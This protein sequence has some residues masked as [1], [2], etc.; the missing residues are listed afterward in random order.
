MGTLSALIFNTLVLVALLKLV[1][2]PE[3]VRLT[4]PPVLLVIPVIVPEP[5]KFIVPVFVKFANAVLIAPTLNN[6]ILDY[7]ISKKELNFLEF[8]QVGRS[9]L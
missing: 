7:G 1:I 6:Q 2:V 8:G 5:T 4:V 3:L 9:Y